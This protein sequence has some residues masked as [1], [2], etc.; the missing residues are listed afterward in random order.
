MLGFGT[1]AL[2]LCVCIH[3]LGVLAGAVTLP[4]D[5]VGK[6]RGILRYIGDGALMFARQPMRVGVCHIH[7][8]R[9]V[10]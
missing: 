5:W 6:Y 7:F 8:A 10:R 9:A 1:Y 2:Q 3:R 4:A